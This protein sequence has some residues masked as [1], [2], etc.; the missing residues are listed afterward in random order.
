[1]DRLREE[2]GIHVESHHVI[3]TSD[4]TD[5]KWWAQIKDL[6]WRFTNHTEA[7]TEERYGL[8]YPP[9]IDAVTQSLGVGF[10]GTDRSTMTMVAMRRVRDWQHGFADAVRIFPRFFQAILLSYGHLGTNRVIKLD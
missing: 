1:M 5:P 3:V 8:W 6:G 7:R 2:R 4:E 9:L 10:V